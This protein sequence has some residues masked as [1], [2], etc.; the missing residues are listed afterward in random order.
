[1]GNY[2]QNFFTKS[3]FTG[4]A[5]ADPWGGWWTIFYWCNWLAWA[6]VS[7]MFLGRISYGHTIRKALVVVFLLPALFDMIWMLIFGAATIHL[8]MNGMDIAAA[9]AKGAEY[10]VYAVFSNYPLAWL[11]IPVFVIAMFLSFVTG[12]DAYTTT[13]GGMSLDGLNPEDP[14]PPI[15]LKVFWGVLMGTVSWI[16]ISFAGGITGVKMLSNLGGGP[17]LILELLMMVCLIKVAARP[18]FYDTFKED[19]NEDGEPLK[20]ISQPAAHAKKKEVKES[21]VA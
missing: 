18:K 9:L 11:T 16:M 12:A 19:Y 2:L 8:Q 21:A 14:E 10:T 13:L 6:P 4:A 20:S 1:M 17:A 15:S 7:G 3:L 5:A